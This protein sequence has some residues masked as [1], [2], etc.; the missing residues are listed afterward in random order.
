MLLLSVPMNGLI[1]RYTQKR[2]KADN[3]METETPEFRDRGLLRLGVEGKGKQEL[4]EDTRRVDALPWGLVLIL[5]RWYFGDEE[6]PL[7]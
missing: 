7:Q 3:F 1:Q 2:G 4:T 6:H 5:G